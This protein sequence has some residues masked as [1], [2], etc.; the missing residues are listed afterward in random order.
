MMAWNGNFKPLCRAPGFREA[1]SAGS[2][3]GRSRHG[4]LQ[5]SVPGQTRQIEMA[6]AGGGLLSE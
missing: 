1:L 5:A 4:E 6:G 3:R 2:A